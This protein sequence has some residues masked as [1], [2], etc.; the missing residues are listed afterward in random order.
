SMLIWLALA[1]PGMMLAAAGRRLGALIP[2]AA[3]MVGVAAGTIVSWV[4]GISGQHVFLG[5]NGSIGSGSGASF[6]SQH[7]AG[8]IAVNLV[9]VSLPA[10]AVAARRARP[11]RQPGPRPANADVLAGMVACAAGVAVIAGAGVRSHLLYGSEWSG[12][13]ALDVVV[14]VVVMVAFGAVLGTDRRWWPWALAPVAL[15]L[16]LG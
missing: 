9:L 13:A 7:S 14:S 2:A 1:L 4:T 3:A 6:W 12:A 10:I 15:L 16:S 8:A 11:G 5:V